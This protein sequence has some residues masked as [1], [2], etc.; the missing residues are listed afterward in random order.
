MALFGHG[1]FVIV[2]HGGPHGLGGFPL[3]APAPLGVPHALGGFPTAAAVHH[4]RIPHGGPLRIP[5]GVPPV[6]VVSGG[7]GGG[8][9]G[10]GG[11]GGHGGPHIHHLPN[12][13]SRGIDYL[14]R[15]I[16][17]ENSTG[18]TFYIDTKGVPRYVETDWKCGNCMMGK[19]CRNTYCT[20]NHP[21]QDKTLWGRHCKHGRCCNKPSCQSDKTH[22]HPPS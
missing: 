4:L 14:G 18:L 6:I 20:L 22:P 1:Q 7:G 10:S 16:Y 15:P 21:Y 8:G 11:G 9:R 2:G 3:L 17:T 12:A 13:T 5:H 19:H